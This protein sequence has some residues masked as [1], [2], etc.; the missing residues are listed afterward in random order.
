M[1]VESTKDVSSDK[2]STSSSF[3]NKPKKKTKK[4]KKIRTP[5]WTDRILYYTNGRLHHLL[6]GSCMDMMMSDHKP[7]C[8]AFLLQVTDLCIAPGCQHDHNL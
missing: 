5:S 3:V 6:Y 8:S 1:S 2:G 4:P 7:V